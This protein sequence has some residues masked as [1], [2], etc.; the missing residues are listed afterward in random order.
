VSSLSVAPV[1]TPEP[2]LELVGMSA[3]YNGSPVVRNINLTVGAGEIVALLGANGA[4]KT[5]TL[6]VIAGLIKPLEG[7]ITLGGV[8]IVGKSA[9]KL[10][11][12]GVSLVP[13]DRALFSE[14]TTRE[15]LR[16]AS[17]RGTSKESEEQILEL[18]PELRKCINRKAGLL[19]G[20]EQQMLAVGRA[21]V[22]SP[23][24]LIVDEMS[25]GLAP[26]VVERLLPVLHDVATTLGTAVLVVEQHVTLAIDVASRAYVLAHGRITLEGTSED[27]KKNQALITASYFGDLEVEKEIE[28]SAPKS[29]TRSKNPG[30]GGSP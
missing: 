26:V 5:T 27:L 25:L 20:G 28:A 23:R 1:G 10:A 13:E 14:L 11:R 19:S 6:S 8:S 29:V 17:A 4:G 22:S 3:G 18:L 9:H 30:L 21:L 12:E 15:N 7:T 16:I 2:L 24:L